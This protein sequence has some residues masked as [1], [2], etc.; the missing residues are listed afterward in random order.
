MPDFTTYFKALKQ[1]KPEEV[2]EHT[3]RATLENLLN[4]IKAEQ[5]PQIKII[6]EP[7]RIE[8]YGAPDFKLILHEGI[9]GYV[10]NK[11]L[12]VNLE[13][14]LKSDQ[15]SRYKKLSN[16]IVLTNYLDWIWLKDGKI[17][18]RA[19][20]CALNELQQPR[21]KEEPAQVQKV[22]KMLSGFLST[23]PEGIG[24]P[25]TLAKALGQRGQLLKT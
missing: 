13:E 10:E 11:A 16:N 25:Q 24:N 3:H 8:D 7:K 1:Y 4:G 22:L 23:A 5:N 9:L 21:F 15:I 17:Q 14:I 19:S 20:L 6:H 12:G 18:D 2:T